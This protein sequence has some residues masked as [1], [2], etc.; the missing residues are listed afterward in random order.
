MNKIISAL[1]VL[2]VSAGAIIA[3][4]IAFKEPVIEDIGNSL[5]KKDLIVVTSP[6]PN[7]LVSS[8]LLI[9]GEARG[10]W[11]FEASFPVRI[12]DS[13]GNEL[14]VVPAQAFDDWMTT[15][16]VPF[17]AFLEFEKPATEYGTLILE[18]DNPSGLPQFEDE[19]HIPVKFSIP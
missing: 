14:G 7:D 17:Q 15:D 16:F 6:G 18:K 11:Y 13:N 19:M 9:T 5:E 2:V 1:L 8:P 10:S 12:E 4:Y 3:G